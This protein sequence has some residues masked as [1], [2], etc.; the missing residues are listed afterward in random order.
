MNETT[1]GISADWRAGHLAA[2]ENPDPV[3]RPLVLL[4]EAAITL[5]NNHARDQVLREGAVHVLL[6]LRRLLV[7]PRGRL[8]ASTI[9]G[10]ILNLMEA[11][12]FDPD[13]EEFITLG[14]PGG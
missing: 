5:C 2:I 9:E 11:C 13:R 6:G 7:G 8:D 3:E 4:M 12:D 1:R 14:G 10:L